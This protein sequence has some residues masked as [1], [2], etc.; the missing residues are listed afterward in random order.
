MRVF[1]KKTFEFRGS[2]F[3]RNFLFVASTLVDPPPPEVRTIRLCSSFALYTA[4]ATVVRRVVYE[5]GD[6]F[7]LGR[8]KKKRIAEYENKPNAAAFVKRNFFQ[9]TPRMFT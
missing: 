1:K 2:E 6:R 9:D 7:L 8:R 3:F 4:A 5:L